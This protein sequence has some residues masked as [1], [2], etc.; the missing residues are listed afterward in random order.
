MSTY[1]ER[2]HIDDRFVKV[3]QW[4][5][6]VVV[7]ILSVPFHFLYEWLGENTVVGLFFPINE[8]IWEHL[9]LVFWPLL[10]WWILGYII[11]KH[12]KDLDSKKWFTAAAFSIMFSMIFIVAWYYTWVY[13]L[14]VESSIIDIGSL[15]IAVPIA[16][17]IA[18]HLY[19]V[20][21]PR[22]LYLILSIVLLM[23]FSG[24]FIWFTLNTPDL[25]LFIPPS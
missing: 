6:I 14:H 22:T 19:K 4:I 18:I 15:F 13:A 2:V 12:R 8:S 21:T 20:V 1:D 23:L 9:K 7:C 5:G 10:V 24:M 17:L 16:Q 25:P 11:F 3:Y